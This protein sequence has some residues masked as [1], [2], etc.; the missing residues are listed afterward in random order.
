M[1]CIFYDFTCELDSSYWLPKLSAI[2][3]KKANIFIKT[4][5]FMLI[6]LWKFNNR[7]WKKCRHKSRALAKYKWKLMKGYDYCGILC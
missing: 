5:W 3:K 1:G 2:K 4:K 7:K 6:L